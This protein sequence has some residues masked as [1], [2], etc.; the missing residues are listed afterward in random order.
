MTKDISEWDASDAHLGGVSNRIESSTIIPFI[1]RI[2]SKHLTECRS[3]TMNGASIK[4]SNAERI[5]S[6]GGSERTQNKSDLKI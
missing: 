1:K 5:G 4:T 2:T 6:D 3:E